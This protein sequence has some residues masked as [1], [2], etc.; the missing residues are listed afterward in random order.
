[1]GPTWPGKKLGIEI[2]ARSQ[3]GMFSR[4]H[5]F[6]QIRIENPATNLEWNVGNDQTTEDNRGKRSV[7]S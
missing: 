1:M 3:T 6:K 2:K 5:T 7:E 4:R